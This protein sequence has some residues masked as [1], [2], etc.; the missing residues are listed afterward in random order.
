MKQHEKAVW[1]FLDNRS[2]QASPEADIES[3]HLYVCSRGLGYNSKTHKAFR[4]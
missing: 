4:L 1:P 3:V 2:V